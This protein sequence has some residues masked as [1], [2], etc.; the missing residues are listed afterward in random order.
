MYQL[1]VEIICQ[2]DPEIIDLRQLLTTGTPKGIS[3]DSDDRTLG[4]LPST[5]N[6]QGCSSR[7]QQIYSYLLDSLQP[8]GSIATKVGNRELAPLELN[9][10]LILIH[11]HKTRKQKV[12]LSDFNYVVVVS[13]RNGPACRFDIESHHEAFNRLSI[14]ELLL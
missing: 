11:G 1:D 7:V 3:V 14:K 10:L 13:Q 6:Y 2:K 4:L 5:L 8:Y 12:F 9:E